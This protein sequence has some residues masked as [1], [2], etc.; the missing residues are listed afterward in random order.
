MICIGMNSLPVM[1]CSVGV[2]GLLAAET[3]DEETVIVLSAADVFTTKV[4]LR[5]VLAG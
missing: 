2:G 3:L 5:K 1:G 4:L